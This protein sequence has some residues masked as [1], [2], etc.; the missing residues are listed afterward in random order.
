M[1]NGKMKA[2]TFSFDD[3]VTQDHRLIKL[4][5]KY[6][7]KAT[8]NLNS[9]RLAEDGR[10]FVQGRSV[11]HVRWNPS[12]VAE[13]Y[14]GHE[15]AGHTLTHKW[16]PGI[17]NGDVLEQVERDRENLKALVGY[18]IVGMAYPCGGQNWDERVVNLLKTETNLQYARSIT[19]TYSFDLQ[20]E[21]LRFD[22][23]VHFCDWGRLFEL[24][25]TFVEM[26]PDRPQLF[27]IWGHSYELDYEFG[28]Y[29]DRW[30]KFEEFCA[31]ISGRE[32]IF[33]GTNKDVFLGE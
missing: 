5:D 29:A 6:G 16:L 22:P 24:G 28:A 25:K 33:Y 30:A 32:D 9:G 17:T 11:P 14:K 15:V 7:L 3:G 26:K 2:I 13:V 8:F 31:Y 27:Y 1:F 10:Q 19:C 4:L 23:T 20:E 18:D 21:L 12:E